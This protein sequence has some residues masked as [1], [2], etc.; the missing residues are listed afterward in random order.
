M[1]GRAVRHTGTGHFHLFC[2]TEAK[3]TYIRFLS[4]GLPLESRLLDSSDLESWYRHMRASAGILNKQQAAEA[5]S[6]TFLAKRVVSN[7]SYYG[8][9]SGPD[10]TL[11]RIVDSLEQR[12]KKKV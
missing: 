2:P 9:S 10:E 3:D 5:L 8:T 11:S 4:D 1:Q 7:P 12:E 6:S